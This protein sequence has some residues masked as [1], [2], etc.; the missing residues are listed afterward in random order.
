MPN[1]EWREEKL[2]AAWPQS[3]PQT[4]QIIGGGS[5][6]TQRDFEDFMRETD[7]DHICDIET[8][9]MLNGWCFVRNYNTGNLYR[10][11]LEQMIQGG[12]GKF[13]FGQKFTLNRGLL[14]APRVEP[15]GLIHILHA[16]SALCRFTHSR[17]VD[18][19]K[20]HEWVSLDHFM[21][22]PEGAASGVTCDEC[23]MQA[24]D[25]RRKARQP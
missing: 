6:S 10:L 11:T 14:S 2:T 23:G 25:L 24:T 16:G 9:D 22:V 5:V 13:G 15:K 7:G 20:G 19:P 17:P 3:H 21:Q 1:D 4:R 8:V 18:W 12:M